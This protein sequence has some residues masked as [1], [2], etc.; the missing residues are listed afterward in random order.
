L[1]SRVTLRLGLLSCSITGWFGGLAW[2]RCGLLRRG[3]RLGSLWRLGNGLSRV[4]G[5]RRGCCRRG[6][7]NRN[8]RLLYL[9]GLTKEVPSAQDKAHDNG[10]SGDSKERDLL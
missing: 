9:R 10:Q 6:G 5:G 7:F 2:F 3:R 4:H 1:L 8:R